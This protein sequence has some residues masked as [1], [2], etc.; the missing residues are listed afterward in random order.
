MPYFDH[1]ATTPIHPDVLEKMYTVSKNHF[2]NPSSTHSSGRKSRAIIEEARCQIASAIN[3]SPSEI[4]FTGGGSEANNMVLWTLTQTEKK[5]VITS[6]I[7]H[8]AILKVLNH[9]EPLGI[10]Y[11]IIPVN[12]HGRVNADNLKNAIRSDTGLISI[13][14][15][16]NEVGSIQ[17]IISLIKIAKSVGI[18]FHSDTV[19]ALGK[20]ALSVQEVEADY[21][22]FS[23]HKLY[24]PKGVGFLY[25]RKD[26][27]L[28]P[29]VIGG[30]QESNFR[31]GTENVPGIAGMG[32][33]V[34]LASENLTKRK[35]HLENLESTFITQLNQACDK[36]IINGCPNH[37]LPGVIS[38]SFPGNRSDILLAKLEREN[39]E[40]SSGSACGSGSIQPSAVLEAIGMPEE[41]NISTIRISFGR[42]NTEEDVIRLAKTLGSITR[43]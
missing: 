6:A 24:G 32:E 9:L 31:A 10:T 29:L 16:N 4:I 17:P 39:M 3:A 38:A 28:H 22:S 21:L 27:P 23:A 20:I 37:H 33:A 5:H 11:S 43:G 41:Q 19:Q 1:C 42:E 8:P 2:G 13:M 35:E 34:R 7:E 12:N 18:P 15:A 36:V 26:A 40:V 25:K 30:G 14:M